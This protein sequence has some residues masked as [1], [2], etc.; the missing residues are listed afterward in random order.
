MTPTAPT[1]RKTE[2]RL[3]LPLRQSQGPD[4]SEY[5]QEGESSGG[6]IRRG[7]D[8]NIGKELAADYPIILEAW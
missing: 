4:A 7:L 2:E 1:S 8:R 5:L 6:S 3:I